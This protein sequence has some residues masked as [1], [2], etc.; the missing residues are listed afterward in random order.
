M[1]VDA[2]KVGRLRK[3]VQPVVHEGLGDGVGVLLLARHLETGRDAH[4]LV[5]RKVFRKAAYAAFDASHLGSYFRVG[6]PFFVRSVDLKKQAVAA[7]FAREH[8]R[9]DEADD[10]HD[11][12]RGPGV[13][14]PLVSVCAGHSSSSGSSS[15]P[16]VGTSLGVCG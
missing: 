12:V 4:V 5:E 8:G 9:A 15:D 2:A 11:A 1:Q 7:C 16:T 6:E 3:E 10:G 13:G 14:E